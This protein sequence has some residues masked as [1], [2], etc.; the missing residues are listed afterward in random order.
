M[1]I[2]DEKTLICF[3]SVLSKPCESWTLNTE[4]FVTTFRTTL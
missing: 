3:L 1:T 4:K 2:N